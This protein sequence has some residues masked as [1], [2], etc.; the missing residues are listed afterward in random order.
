MRRRLRN[1]VRDALWSSHWLQLPSTGFNRLSPDI[2]PLI[3]TW[4]YT[5]RLLQ[6][7]LRT[8]IVA[9]LCAVIELLSFRCHSF[10][11]PDLWESLR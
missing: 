4:L 6:S 11:K 5:Q 2:N 10:A 8:A 3:A 7:A 9:K 1:S